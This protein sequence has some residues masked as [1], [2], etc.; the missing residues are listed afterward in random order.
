[1]SNLKHTDFYF[2]YEEYLSMFS[3]VFEEVYG[4]DKHK[5]HPEDFQYQAEAVLQTLCKTLNEMI[6]VKKSI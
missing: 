6:I 5:W 1:M 3:N 4:T 2:T